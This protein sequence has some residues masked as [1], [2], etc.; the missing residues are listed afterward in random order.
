MRILVARRFETM[1]NLANELGVTDR[2][3]RSDILIL[4]VDH[5]LETVRGN[6]GGVKVSEWYRP[7]KNILSREQEAVLTEILS[8]TD[9]PHH[10]KVL[11]ELLSAIGSPKNKEHYKIGVLSE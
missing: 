10:Q 8:E 1:S 4:T 7:Y 9:N 3:I 6:G 5:P 2:T 11:T